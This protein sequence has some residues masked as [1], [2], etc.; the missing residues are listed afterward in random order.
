MYDV[1]RN[2]NFLGRPENVSSIVF[3]ILLDK[4]I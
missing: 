1:C 2:D 4:K 3:P